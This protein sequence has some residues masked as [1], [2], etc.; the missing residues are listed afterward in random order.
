M[1]KPGRRPRPSILEKLPKLLQ[2]MFQ[3]SYATPQARHY[4]GTRIAY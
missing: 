1:T 3:G 2:E 4:W